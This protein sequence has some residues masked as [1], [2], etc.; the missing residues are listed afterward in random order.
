MTTSLES[1]IANLV[2]RVRRELLHGREHLVAPITL[3]CPGVLSGSQGPLLFTI[4]EL[5]DSVKRWELV[6]LVVDHPIRNGR[7]LSARSEGVLDK[8][9]VGVLK[10]SRIQNG[11]LVGEGWFDAEKTKRVDPRVYA[12]LTNGNPMEVSTG[13]NTTTEDVPAGTTWQGVPYIAVARRL[14]PD[15]LAILPTARGACSLEDGCGLLV[16]ALGDR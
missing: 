2:G 3:I 1:L 6:P 4:G 11:K 7:P 9:G 12:A 13:L 15:H 5:K 10:N 14:R 16:H 8:S